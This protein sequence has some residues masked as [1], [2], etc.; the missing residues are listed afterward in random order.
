MEK[1]R[2]TNIVAIIPAKSTSRRVPRKNMR[3]LDK[4]P[5]IF[6]SITAALK[7]SLI[8]EVYVSTDSPEIQKYAE[9]LGAK[10]PFLRPTEQC[11][12][13]IHSSV[14][15]LDMLEKIGGA[16]QYS[17]C[18]GMLPTSPFRTTEILDKIIK[19]SQ[20]NKRNILS[21]MSLG[22][23]FPH[24]RT[25][26]ANGELKQLTEKP[27]R[28]FQTQDFPNL[29]QLTGVAQCAPVD[30]LLKQKTFHY[31][32]P[33]GYVVTR[34]EGFDIDTEEDFVFAEKLIKL[35]KL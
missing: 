21:V 28:N 33:L 3:E 4:K 14:P 18:V 9:S 7:S 30:E 22:C 29:Y 35:L 13:N 17:Y 8:D 25:L 26:G 19:M 15:I 32:N 20:E 10:A 27:V 16:N 23:T 31:G 5:L 11:A 6:Y 24:L 12:D 1:A 2:T 34:W